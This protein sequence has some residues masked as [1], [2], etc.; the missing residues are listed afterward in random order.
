MEVTRCTESHPPLPIDEVLPALIDSLAR[1]GSVVLR[2]PPGAGKTTRVPPAIVD[3]GLAAEKQVIVLQPRRLAARSAA[4]HVSQERG[5]S[6]GDEVGYQVRFEKR[7]GR[8]TRILYATDGVFIRLLQEDP[9]L[10]RFAAVVFDEFHERSLHSD[11]A[12]AMVRR[13][14]REVRPDLKLVV[15]SATIVTQP[16]ASF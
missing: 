14:Q 7:A 3:A 9:F 15:M 5:G 10:E 6:V 13:V 1:I 16:V 4:W 8:Q 2:A 12:L 11:L